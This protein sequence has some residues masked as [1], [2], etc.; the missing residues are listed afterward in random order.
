MFFKIVFRSIQRKRSALESLFDKIADLKAR[1]ET[2]TQ[3]FS[4]EYYKI[5]RNTFFAE[6]LRWLFL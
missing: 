2:S 3:V 6:H 1:E 4:C 5:F